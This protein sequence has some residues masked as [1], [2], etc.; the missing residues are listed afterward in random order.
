MKKFCVIGN[1]INHSVSPAIFKYV[2]N[3]FNIKATYD[4]KLIDSSESFIDFITNNR[5][6]YSGFNITSP[7]KGMAYDIVDELS[8]LAKESK[9]VNCIKVKNSQLIGY[10]TDYYGFV[11]MLFE[12]N[13]SLDNKKILVLGYGDVARTIIF[14]LFN[15]YNCEIYIYGRNKDKI[16][17]LIT[18]IKNKFNNKIINLYDK[19]VDHKLILINCL[20]LKIDS[21][22][23]KSLLSYLPIT[24]I[25]KCIDLNYV[26]SELSLG[27]S[28]NCEI[29]SG[30][31]MLIYQAIKSFDLWF[32]NKYV[33]KINYL[34]LKNSII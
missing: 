30:L 26:Q 19:Q 32:D 6:S 34:D 7:Y 12:N 25:D 33:E 17:N 15:E 14:S 3:F 21:K 10:N 16:K 29:I 13:I 2:F 5:K 31:D 1:P 20:P 24:D 4:A 22:N 23:V 8:P 11:N 9:S 28:E 27:I 18:I